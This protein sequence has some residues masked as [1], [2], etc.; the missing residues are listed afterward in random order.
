M[1]MSASAVVI[2]NTVCFMGIPRVSIF[3]RAPNARATVMFPRCGDL[4]R[5]DA[6]GGHGSLR[7]KQAAGVRRF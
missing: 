3:G 1:A 6:R 5:R 7:E 2:T 4:L